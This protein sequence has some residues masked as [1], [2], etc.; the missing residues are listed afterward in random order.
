M[1]KERL[2]RAGEV[3]L[4]YVKSKVYLHPTP[5]K[6]DNI[7]GFLSLSRGPLAT[8][9]DILLSF[10]AENQLSK[11]EIK[12]YNNVDLHE[13]EV[14]LEALQ[15][16]GKRLANAVA[17]KKRE[18]HI[19][20]KPPV[21][22]LVGYSFSIPL[23]FV[24]SIQVRKPSSGFWHGSL[25][26]NTKDGEKLPILFFH[27]NESASTLK[28]QKIRNQR[29][30]PF[31][32]SGDLYWGGDDFIKVLLKFIRVVKSTVET[33]VLLINPDEDDL[34]NFANNRRKSSIGGDSSSEAATKPIDF[35]MPNI[36]KFLNNAKWRV[37][38]TVATLGAQTKNQVVDLVD[39]H[40][41][42]P[43]KQLMSKPE[44]KKIGDDFDS[45]RIYLAKWAQQVKE[46]AEESLK[47]YMLE[48]DIYN[49]INKELGSDEYLTEEEINKTSR[50]D[51]IGLTEWKSF[52]DYSGRLNITAN[53]IKSKIFHG[54]LEPEVRKEA[55]LFLLGVYSWDTSAKEREELYA[56]Y[57]TAY[58]DYKLKWVED[59]EKRSTEFWMDQKHR[60]EKD[61]HRTD[62]NIEIF[63]NKKTKRTSTTST[64][65]NANNSN[66]RESSPET[67]D[68]ASEPEE[69]EED[70]FNLSNIRNP[71][72]FNVR[73]ILLTYNEY[74]VNL[75][76]VQGMS[77]L[78]S[79]LY[80]IYQDEVLTFWTFSKF[81]E[82]MERNFV[83]DQSGMKKQMLTLN[84]LLQFML[85]K[86]YK[87]LE[88]C[89]SV[90]LF[91]FFRMLL[92]WFKREFEWNDV[93][94]LWETLFTNCYSSQFHLFVALAVLSANERIII[95]NLQ[96]FDEVLKYMN[97][98]SMK[99]H[100]DPLLIR[101][102]LLFLK[103][104]RMI[105]I[106][107]RENSIARS[108]GKFDNV[109]NVDH[110]LRQLL[111]KEPII[112]K[113]VERPEGVGGG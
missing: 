88:K 93:F 110:E 49:Q 94:H 25:V 104:K 96:Q 105:D 29:F 26:I 84:K 41:P 102:E 42:V 11:E 4:L 62:R 112:Q 14:D 7:C 85:P 100:L 46:E 113:E 72:L 44:V 22:I 90:D 73:E 27:D 83:R 81:M 37:L 17:S 89:Q 39:E 18:D 10:S 20:T 78:I 28:E 86:L 77:D 12:I 8:N 80:F 16:S 31:N 95:Q 66:E 87:H 74:N 76:Y 38:E 21:S 64:G 33:S 69:N 67:P 51:P 36:G 111:N 97:D 35:K 82:I 32:S 40:A 98:L 2:L 15:I 103:F 24:F 71:H 34:R 63:Q 59:T 57:E 75:G 54:G 1:V 5:S 50:R 58:S 109:V 70:E 101:S 68:E 6:K 9:N 30:D 65:E 55:W 92:V 47:K 108:S 107:D 56:S 19:V 48:D 3:E 23:S 91:F 53:E 99:M 43:L 13:L 45:A 106:I 61:I 79:P 52:F 60:I